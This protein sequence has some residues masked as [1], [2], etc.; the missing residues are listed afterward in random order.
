VI[1]LVLSSSAEFLLSRQTAFQRP[2]LTANSDMMIPPIWGDV[3]RVITVLY[4]T[5]RSLRTVLRKSKYPATAKETRLSY[6]T[7]R[8]VDR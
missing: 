7:V 2:L 1:C 4:R 3:T 8:K 6:I 5:V